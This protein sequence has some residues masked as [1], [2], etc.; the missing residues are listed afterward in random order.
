MPLGH[1]ALAMKWQLVTLT[2]TLILTLLTVPRQ[3]SGGQH[4]P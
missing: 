2:Q 1:R 3:C 4:T